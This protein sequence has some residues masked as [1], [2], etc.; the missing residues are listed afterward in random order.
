MHALGFG[1]ALGLGRSEL[2]SL[3]LASLLARLGEREGAQPLAELVDSW[4]LGELGSSV[5][6]AVHGGLVG[7]ESGPL[8]GQVLRLV[9]AYEDLLEAPGGLSPSAA[10]DRLAS[11]PPQGVLRELASELKRWKGSHPLGSPLRLDDSRLAIVIGWSDS[12][13][14][15]GLPR[16]LPVDGDRLGQALDLAEPGSPLPT[17]QPSPA[18]LGLDLSRLQPHEVDGLEA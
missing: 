11:E 6:L 1:S 5:F 18:Q 4:G 2:M 15:R 7:D 9:R 10:L 8:P 3:G 13:R 16:V 12:G 17:E 14:A